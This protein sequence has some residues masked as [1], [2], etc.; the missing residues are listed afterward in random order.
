M[1]RNGGCLTLFLSLLISGLM[2][3]GFSLIRSEGYFIQWQEL[4][5]APV[6]FVSFKASRESS[7]YITISNEAILIWKL[8]HWEEVGE[9]PSDINEHWN[10]IVPCDRKPPQF[11][12]LTNA[13]QNIVDCIQDEGV[14]AEFYNKHVY[15]LDEEGVIWEWHLLNHAFVVLVDF[16]ISVFISGIVGLIIGIALTKLRKRNRLRTA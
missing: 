5:D 11:S 16:L 6:N 12:F 8:D 3:C 10:I 14:Y 4:A 13:P 9:I 7:L 15:A 1:R 2:G